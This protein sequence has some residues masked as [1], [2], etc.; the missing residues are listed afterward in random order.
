MGS[1]EYA[2]GCRKEEVVGCGEGGVVGD[3]EVVAS[4]EFVA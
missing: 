2:L 4:E 1:V 3:E